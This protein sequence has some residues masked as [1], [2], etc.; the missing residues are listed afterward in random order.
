MKLSVKDINLVQNGNNWGVWFNIPITLVDKFKKLAEKDCLKSIEVK[1]QR[2]GRSLTSNGYLWTLIDQL[3][4]KIN[5]PKGDLYVKMIKR[6]GKFHTVAIKD[7]AL[8]ELIK[9]WDH[10]NTSVEHTESL[11]D[12][13]NSFRSKGTLWHELM[14]HEGPSGYNTLEFSKLLKGLISECELMGICTMTPSEVQ[15]LMNNYEGG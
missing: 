15:Q 3:A 14:C 13:I 11:C 8:T 7:E 1:E 9:A 12:I 4:Q 5:I 10:S 2:E 6:Y